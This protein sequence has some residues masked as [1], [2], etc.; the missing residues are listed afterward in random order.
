MQEGGTASETEEARM[1]PWVRLFVSLNLKTTQGLNEF[2]NL[3][4]MP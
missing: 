1:R 2:K 4:L 3:A